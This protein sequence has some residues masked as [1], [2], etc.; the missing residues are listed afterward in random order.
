MKATIGIIT[1]QRPEGLAR[2]LNALLLQEVSKNLELNILV[3]D[4]ACEPQIAALSNKIGKRSPFKISYHREPA[5]GIVSARNKCVE[6]F[7]FT[8]SKYLCFIDDD[9]WPENNHWIQTLVDAQSKYKSE[10]IT[11]HV[12]S[13]GEV[14][15]EGKE[16][17]YWAT[18]L[19]YGNNNFVEGDLLTIFYTNNVLISRKVFEQIKPAFDLR[20]AMTGASDYHFALKCLNA[21]FKTYYT[22]APVV[23]EF[24]E[25]RA[26]VKWFARRGYRS[27]IGFTRSHLFES[28]IYKAVPY[29]LIMA[30]S[31]FV[32]GV[33]SLIYGAL[34]FDKLRLINGIFRLS[35][36]VGSLTAFL[37][38]QYQEYKT[39][40][41]K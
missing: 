29:C 1:Y 30:V 16:T 28:P 37:G 25:S 3:V 34:S 35:S 24:P 33:V 10:I 9:E 14:E 32:R 17:P 31:R 18:K 11:S 20:F 21:G 2:L 38:A 8:N 5:K 12:I 27:G 26:T 36:F 39:I 15:I 23:E 13:V 41:G 19:L 40:H 22:D 7:L 6:E 4:N